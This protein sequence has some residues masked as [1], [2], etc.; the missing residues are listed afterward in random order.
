MTPFTGMPHTGLFHTATSFMPAAGQMPL[1]FKEPPPSAEHHIYAT[2]FGYTAKPRAGLKR[3]ALFKALS[4]LTSK[5]V[6]SFL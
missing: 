6:S 2:P 1:H 4:L 5:L 3:Q